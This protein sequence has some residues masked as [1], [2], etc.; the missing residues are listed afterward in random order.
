M[1][2]DLYTCLN[3]RKICVT[4]AASAVPIAVNM[5]GHISAPR[6]MRSRMK[7]DAITYLQLMLGYHNSSH[8]NT[9]NTSR[10]NGWQCD[11]R[12][13]PHHIYGSVETTKW[14]L[15]YQVNG[16]YEPLWNVSKMNRKSTIYLKSVIRT[17]RSW[18]GDRQ[19]SL[20]VDPWILD[21]DM[22]YGGFI[23]F[24]LP[25]CPVIRRELVCNKAI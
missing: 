11:E 10:C 17:A 6:G 20:L 18:I 16:T 8:W 12:I 23:F 22:S 9:L 19:T 13:I 15:K 14:F 4:K 1:V 7:S 24:S 21:R 5:Y 3:P 2:V 25:T